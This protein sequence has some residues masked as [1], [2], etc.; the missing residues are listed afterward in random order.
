MSSLLQLKIVKCSYQHFCAT[1]AP[2]MIMAFMHSFAAYIKIK[3]DKNNKKKIE[4]IAIILQVIY[5]IATLL[6]L[7]MIADYGLCLKWKELHGHNRI[8]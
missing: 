7:L 8:V 6:F 4:A 1:I 5:F 2:H 3:N